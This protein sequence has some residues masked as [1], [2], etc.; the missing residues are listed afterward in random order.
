MSSPK[1][2]L[3]ELIAK[4]KDLTSQSDTVRWTEMECFFEEAEEEGI[5]P[6]ELMHAKDNI[7][8]IWCP[9]NWKEAQTLHPDWREKSWYDIRRKGTYKTFDAHYSKFLK[10]WQAENPETKTTLKPFPKPAPAPVATPRP[11]LKIVGENF[12]Q[13]LYDDDFPGVEIWT[14]AEQ[15]IAHRKKMEAKDRNGSPK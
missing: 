13:T 11:A 15:A 9:I 2:T 8:R 10:A 3:K 7:I 14:S 12:H 6:K 1:V 5:T 4:W